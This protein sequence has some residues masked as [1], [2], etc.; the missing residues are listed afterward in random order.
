MTVLLR[1][2]YWVRELNVIIISLKCV[3][4]INRVYGCMI[5]IKSIFNRLCILVL[6]KNFRDLSCIWCFV[7]FAFEAFVFFVP[8]ETFAELVEFDC[9]FWWFWKPESKRCAETD[10]SV[11]VHARTRVFAKHPAVEVLNSV[12][13]CLLC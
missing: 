5:L 13:S 12:S 11:L 8:E 6:N 10:T 7:S 3:W 4:W 2:L 1:A 9:E